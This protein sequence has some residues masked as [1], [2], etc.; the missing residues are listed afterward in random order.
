M[1]VYLD[2]NILVD[3]EDGVFTLEVFKRTL[4]VEY[5]FS[6]VH[7]DELMNGLEKHPELKDIRLQTIDALCGSNYISPDLG[8]YMKGGFEVMSPQRAFELS[9]QFKNIHDKLYNYTKA[10]QYDRDKMLDSLVMEKKEVGNYKPSEI[11]KVIDERMMEYW[12]YDISTYLKMQGASIGRTVYSSLFNLLDFVC[13]RH[14]KDHAARLYDS[15][16]AYFGQYCDFLVTND[17]RMKTKTEAVYSYLSKT[18]K[19]LTADEYLE[20]I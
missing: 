15:S 8:S 4:N 20:Q 7:M 17:K 3:I 5:Y 18:T 6:E 13:Y 14:D 19:V 16:H 11:F 10:M 2:N 12:G 9:Y 1:R